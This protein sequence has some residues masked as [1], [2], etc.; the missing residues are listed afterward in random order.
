MRAQKEVRS[1]VDK[2]YIILHNTEGIIDRL[3]VE[4]W[5][6]SAI[7]EVWEGN[8]KHIIEKWMKGDPHYI[9]A[10]NLE[11]YLI[12][13]WKREL[14]SNEL[15]WTKEI[16]KQSAESVAWFLLVACSKIKSTKLNWEKNIKQKRN[17]NLVIGDILSLSGL[18]DTKIWRCSQGYDTTVFF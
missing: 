3:L 2:A 18:Q 9:V 10:E 8:E 16:S 1:M 7:G 6:L 17:K 14:T 11:F 4:I 5:I 12:V 13:M 15:N